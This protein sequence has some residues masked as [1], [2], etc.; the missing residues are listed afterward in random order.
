MRMTYERF[1][2]IW[3]GVFG[4]PKPVTTDVDEGMS[5]R[6]TDAIN[7]AESEGR[8]LALTDDLS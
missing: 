5:Q 3:D 8:S 1:K 2:Q 4:G 6:L 7:Q